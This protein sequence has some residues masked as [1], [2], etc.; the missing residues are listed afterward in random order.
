[1]ANHLHRQLREAIE[2]ALTGLATSGSRVYANRLLPLA[3]ANLPGLRISADEE[4]AELLTIH[5]PAAQQRR[6]AL[7]VECCAKGAAI[8]DTLDQMSKEV[9]VALAAG[10]TVSGRVLD[11]A[12]SGMSFDDELADQAIGVKRLRFSITY[13]AMSNA[14]DVLI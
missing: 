4:E 8:D 1:M 12:Y 7:S 14:P 11:V 13:T 2:N 9:E 10:I 6:L 5:A 3:D